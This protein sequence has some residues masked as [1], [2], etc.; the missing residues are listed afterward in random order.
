MCL[1][2]EA[3]NNS[4]RNKNV[5]P[6]SWSGCCRAVNTTDGNRAYAKKKLLDAV[7][8]LSRKKTFADMEESHI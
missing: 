1:A 6:Q 4:H 3:F 2:C 8:F 5:A 7:S